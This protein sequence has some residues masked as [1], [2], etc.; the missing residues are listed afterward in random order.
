MNEK[1]LLLN[2]MDQKLQQFRKLEGVTVP[3]RGWVHAIRVALNMSLRQLGE[4]LQ[5]SVQGVRDIEE[6]ERTGAVSLK[7]LRQ[8]GQALKM[9]LVYS[10]IPEA[11]SL[12]QMIEDRARD[13]AREIV[14]RTSMSMELENQKNT[15]KR[16]KQAIAEKTSEIKESKPRYLWD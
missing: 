13:L 5:M 1:K 11:S 16:L 7:V 2:Q 4:R 15:E 8:V 6:R 10:F 3:P 9:K 14:A 12:E